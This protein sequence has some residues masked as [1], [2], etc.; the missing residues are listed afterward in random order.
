[1]AL[2]DLIQ[3]S[4]S[5]SAAAAQIP[6]FGKP[7]IL[8]NGD[9]KATWSGQVYREYANLTGVAADFLATSAT[10]LQAAAI[11]NQNPTVPL[12]GIGL[13]ATSASVQDFW[14]DE[15]GAS[16]AGAGTVLNFTVNGNAFSYTTVSGDTTHD[17]F[18]TNLVAALVAA[19]WYGASGLTI[20]ADTTNGATHHLV[21]VVCTAAALTDIVITQA[22][23]NYLIL[24]QACT[25]GGSAVVA[26]IEAAISADLTAIAN[27]NNTWYAILSPYVSAVEIVG[28]AKYAQANTK[29]FIYQTSDTNNIQIA[30]ATDITLAAA[31]PAPTQPPVTSTSA[32]IMALLANGG[33]SR[34]LG[35]YT[36][37][38]LNFSDGAWAGAKLWTTPGSEFWAYTTL[39]GVSA[40]ILTESQR[41]A[42]V[43]TLGLPSLKY[44]S[45]Y[46]SV[47]GLNITELGATPG[48]G[49]YMDSIRFLDWVNANIQGAILTA[50]VAASNSG[51]K[52]PYTQQGIAFVCGLVLAVLKQGIT[53]GGFAAV[54]APAVPVPQLANISASNL[55]ARNL[56]NIAWTATEAGAIQN[57]AVQG[58]VTI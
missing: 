24:Y 29:V 37:T 12:V 20:T 18:I 48:A 13:R 45:V 32:S 36:H 41:N 31:T 3:T 42:I 26:T 27:A 33:Y 28:C 43:G 46:E 9:T 38:L 40:T 49:N 17:T 1:M 11:F 15:L 14:I 51:T 44:G 57:A 54:P 2:S 35:I 39:A 5:L 53:N 16:I 52:I 8:A 7:L 47:G 22:N 30:A 23:L 50:F 34:S 6:G 58:N 55:S 25:V 19:A 10:Y 21:K 56:P 4:T